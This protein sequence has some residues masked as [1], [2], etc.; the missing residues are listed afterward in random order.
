MEIVVRRSGTV[1][2]LDI[3]GKM[4]IGRG[5]QLLH[6]RFLDLLEAGERRFI[7]NMSA[8]RYV[9]SACVGETLAC[10]ARARERDAVIKIVLD[11]SGRPH[12]D[13]VTAD[14]HR[15]FEIFADERSALDSFGG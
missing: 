6:R 9:D 3:S 7:F 15:L 11:P 13:F 14:L 5:E 12:R 4:T 10:H 1:S 8:V 2:I